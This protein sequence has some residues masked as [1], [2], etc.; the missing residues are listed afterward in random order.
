[1]TS[2]CN[3]SAFPCG[4]KEPKDNTKYSVENVVSRREKR[5]DL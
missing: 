2:K 5:T 4:K 1:M 3:I